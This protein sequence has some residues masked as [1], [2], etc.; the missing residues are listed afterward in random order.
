MNEK[1]IASRSDAHFPY[2]AAPPAA[3]AVAGAAEL[4]LPAAALA[5]IV[6]AAAA[7]A[8]LL[9]PAAGR[10][11]AAPAAALE[12]AAGAAV[13]AA[14]LLLLAP[15]AGSVVAGAAGAGAALELSAGAG[16]GAAP[17]KLHEGFKDSVRGTVRFFGTIYNL[18]KVGMLELKLL[19]RPD[20]MEQQRKTKMTQWVEPQKT[21]LEL[22]GQ[23]LRTRLADCLTR[24]QRGQRT[25]PENSEQASNVNVISSTTSN[26]P[27]LSCL[28]NTS[29]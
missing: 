22:E 8:A 13:V 2:A 9:A 10:V 28:P 23:I 21:L 19:D 16:A 3:G 26:Y 29:F 24:Q 7:G 25:R 12:A 20:K 18:G 17:A 1:S 15:D 27:I 11:V 14:A 5:G 6:V 4:A